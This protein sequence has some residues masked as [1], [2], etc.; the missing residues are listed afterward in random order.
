MAKGTTFESR[1][2]FEGHPWHLVSHMYKLLLFCYARQTPCFIQKWESIKK[3]KFWQILT[4]AKP[5]LI[6]ILA[7]PV[8]KRSVYLHI[9]KPLQSVKGSLQRRLLCRGQLACQQ[10]LYT[11]ASCGTL[12]KKGYTY[13]S[14]NSLNKYNIQAISAVV[15][16]P[17]FHY[18]LILK[19]HFHEEEVHHLRTLKPTKNIKAAK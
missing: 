14:A 4:K 19:R 6:P 10:P 16:T 2:A 9:L 12:K 13:H 8:K 18:E 7:D 5:T 15:L 3:C 11:E 17:F 1:C